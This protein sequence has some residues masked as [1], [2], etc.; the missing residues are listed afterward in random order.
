[1]KKK[2][3]D[4]NNDLIRLTDRRKNSNKKNMN[5]SN[6]KINLK[7]KTTEETKT[8]VNQTHRDEFN[9]NNIITI[10]RVRPENP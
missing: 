4:E 3:F 8:S 9:N 10:L 7:D 6:E 2:R 1:M 5:I